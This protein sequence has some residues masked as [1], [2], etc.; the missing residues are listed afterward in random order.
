[1]KG[2]ILANSFSSPVVLLLLSLLLVLPLW[3][4]TLIAAM[5]HTSDNYINLSKAD[6]ILIVSRRHELQDI[7]YPPMTKDDE[8]VK[9]KLEMYFKSIGNNQ[10]I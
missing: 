10:T 9:K 6:S 7:E 8:I 5:E 2:E 3:S 4:K 1:M